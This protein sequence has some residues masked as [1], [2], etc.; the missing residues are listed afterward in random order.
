MAQTVSIIGTGYV[1]LV[2][3]VCLADKGIRV[4]CV[5]VNPEIVRKV[6]RGIIPFYEAGLSDLLEKNLDKNFSISGDLGEGV[7]ES[8][9]SLITV[10]T[11]YRRGSADLKYVR[12]SSKAIGIALREANEYKV[13]LVK[14]TVPPGTTDEV[15]TPIVER[16]S[17]K[18]AGADFGVGMNPE[19]LREGC[20]V[21]DFMKP[22]RIVIGGMD[23]RTVGAAAQLYSAFEPCDIINTNNRTAE[24]IKYASN[25]FFSTLISFSNEIGNICASMKDVDVTDVLSAVHLDQRLNPIDQRGE[26]MN[27]GITNYLSAGCGFGGSCFPKDLS[28]II[29]HSNRL[30]YHPSLLASV[31]AINKRQPRKLL[32]LLKQHYSSFKGITVAVLGLSFKPGTDDIRESPAIA[33]I[34]ALTASGARVNAYDPVAND[35]ARRVL[36]KNRIRYFKSMAEAVDGVDAILVVTRWE[37]FHHL[38]SLLDKIQQTPLVIDGRRMLPKDGFA[39]YEGI[40]LKQTRGVH[41]V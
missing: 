15:V 33:L 16:Y 26:R 38:P 23:S 11:P 30:G 5:D 17:R 34:N 28:S 21:N 24:M 3:G 25:C 22:D 10:G 41:G 6:S 19:F 7:L 37:E 32:D 12:E 40:G 29:A 35:S 31:A 8:S 36:G 13:V 2:T 4:R 14:S 1:G 9:I 39:Q 18:K 20:A 27:P